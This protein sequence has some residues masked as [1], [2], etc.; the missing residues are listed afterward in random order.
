[1]PPDRKF[2][3]LLWGILLFRVHETPADGAIELDLKSYMSSETYSNAAAA[4]A[5]AG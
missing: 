1:M 5:A 2:S 3:V 4:A